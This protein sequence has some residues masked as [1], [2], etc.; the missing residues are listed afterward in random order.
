M[1]EDT[2]GQLDRKTLDRF[3]EYH[4]DELQAAMLYQGLADMDPAKADILRQL[5]EA[6]VRHAAHWRSILADNGIEVEPTAKPSMKT[7]MMLRSAKQFG[8]DSVLPIII[9]AEA[10][11]AD[12]YRGVA[13]APTSMAK[14]EM[15]HG[16]RLASIGGA[17]TT[18]AQIAASEGRHR[19]G[20]G[21]AL[22]ASVFGVNDGLVSNFSLVMG[23]AGGTSDAQIVV[24]AGVAGLFAG[25][26]SMAAGEWVSV[27]SQSELYEHEIEAER[28]ELEFFPEEERQ[29][30]E[31]IY[32]AKGI[33]EDEARQLSQRLLDDPDTA[34][35]TLAREELGIDPSEVVG[36]RGA[37]VAAGSSFVSFAIGAL[38]P[39]LPFVL[40]GAGTTQIVVAAI[41]SGAALL[42]VGGSLAVFTGRPVA[43][44][45]L[46]MML[47]GGAAA[48]ATYLIGTI[49]GVV[50]A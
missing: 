37:W 8:V 46:R 7:R 41:L 42:A 43:W 1:T 23:V 3:R 34:L 27:R 38:I 4:E 33:P 12:K 40:I 49:F 22:R 24:L 25:A 45:A 32:R 50:I 39:L 31:L 26:F 5:A 44:S 20:A 48:A 21:G 35:D 16:R 19:T 30:L 10:A 11:D 36:S 2:T 47:I 29:E 9:R 14:E 17:D 6:E 15:A 18:G 13:Q 28:E